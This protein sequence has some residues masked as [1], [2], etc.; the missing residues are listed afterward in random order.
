MRK[1]IFENCERITIQ[2]LKVNSFL[3]GGTVKDKIC[4]L[5]DILIIEV[6][7][8]KAGE[9][10]MKLKTITGKH[11]QT[12]KLIRKSS[13]LNGFFYLFICPK[14]K[15]PC[16]KLNRPKNEQLFLSYRGYN[17]LVYRKQTISAKQRPSIRLFQYSIQLNQ[18][19]DELFKPKKKTH[20]KGKPT[21]L[22]KRLEMIHKKT[23]DLLKKSN[24]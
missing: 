16:Y 7:T 21:P 24:R 9:E 14:V 5:Q 3:T 15:K 10:Q 20:Y 19:E 4:F 1:K 22:I 6:T 13:N 11:L 18:L 17:N 12:I 2:Y 8:G 23:E